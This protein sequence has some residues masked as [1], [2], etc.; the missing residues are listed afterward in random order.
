MPRRRAICSRWR[1][2]HVR[3]G[4]KDEG[5]RWATEAKRLAAEYGQ[6]RAGGVDR[7]ANWAQSE[8]T[9]RRRVPIVVA[10]LLVDR[11]RFCHPQAEAASAPAIAGR[12]ALR[13]GGGAAGLSF[14]HVNGATGQ[15]YMPELMG[16]GVALFDYDN[17]GDL[18]VFLVQGG[19]LG[20]SGTAG[21]RASR[22]AG[23]F[24]TTCRR[25]ATAG[26]RCTSPT[27]P[28]AP[29]SAL[30]RLRHGRGGRRLRQRR[31]PRSLRHVLRPG[32]AL[33]QQRR[34]HLHRRHRRRRA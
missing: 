34:R 12:A 33:S 10:V 24:A 18:D 23:S 16:A 15:Y 9:A 14:T 8:V 2:A 26:A 28:I 3:A 1:S 31:R 30:T 17:D 32:D 21:T 27:S 22:P 4:H 29:A 7:T 13:R 20:R 6:T 19:P 11:R 5:I 25:P